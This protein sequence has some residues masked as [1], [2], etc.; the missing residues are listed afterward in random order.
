MQLVKEK[1]IK[2]EIYEL[3]LVKEMNDLGAAA[4]RP[5]HG[6]PSSQSQENLTH[7]YLF[8][9]W[10]NSPFAPVLPPRKRKCNETFVCHLR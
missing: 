1:L 5:P 2:Y 9:R 3:V 10:P 4:P 7:R 6:Q 8:A